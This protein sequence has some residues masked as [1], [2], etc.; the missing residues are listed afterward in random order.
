MHFH[1]E[2]VEAIR[3]E[4][5]YCCR[6]RSA[7]RLFGS[8]ATNQRGFTL[9]ELITVMVIVGVLAAVAVPR[10]FD[11]N[12]FDSQ[13]FHD[14]V[15]STLRYAQKEAI[16]QRRF[17]CVAIAGNAVT[18]TYDATPPSAAHT[19]ASCPGNPLTNPATGVVP[20]TVSSSVGVTV[21]AA[22]FSFDALGRSSAQSITVSGNAPITVE[23]ETGYVH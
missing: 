9:T 22:T 19:A 6:A 3:Q 5:V 17:V 23:A 8:C 12:T 4:S 20:Y 1:A 15:I 14:Q 7:A 21:S 16:A 18:L 2:Q 13:A 11:R 10:F